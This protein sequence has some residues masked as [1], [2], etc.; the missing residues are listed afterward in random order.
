MHKNMKK[1]SKSK[2]YITTVILSLLLLWMPCVWILANGDAVKQADENPSSDAPE[3]IET[4]IDSDKKSITWYVR[5]ISGKPQSQEAYLSTD[6]I[7][8][9]ESGILGDDG[10][11]A[12][13]TLILLDNSMSIS[14]YRNSI[15][16]ILVR[17]IWNH[18]NLE[19]FAIATFDT[20]TNILVDYTDNYDELRM[21]AENITYK[22]QATYLRNVI[23]NEIIA[24]SRDKENYFSRI[25]IISDGTDDSIL[26]TTYEELT[27]LL[28][29]DATLCPI[30]TIGC[31]YKPSETGLD[32][33]FALSRLTNSPYCAMGDYEAP[34]DIADV[35]DRDGQDIR[36][37]TFSLDLE[38]LD[39]SDKVIHLLIKD[40]GGEH[41][42]SHTS[43]MQLDS[44]D[45][46]HTLI[47][48]KEKE[49]KEKAREEKAAAEKAARKEVE[50]E[51]KEAQATQAGEVRDGENEDTGA[52]E[53]N[54]AD[55]YEQ[56]NHPSTLSSY[57]M[58][59]LSQN[60]VWIMFFLLVGLAVFT[61]TA[62]VQ[63]RKNNRGFVEDTE[64]DELLAGALEQGRITKGIVLTDMNNIGVKYS[65]EIG[66]EKVVG[67][68]RSRCD[69]AFPTDRSMSARQ[70]IIRVTTDE[71]V[72]ENLDTHRGSVVDGEEITDRASLR[73]GSRIRLGNTVLR[74]T[75]E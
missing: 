40:A 37:F 4:H 13:K 36:Y 5:G 54:S 43:H 9:S 12:P 55:L 59:Y 75:Y 52:D 35:I 72:L 10:G 64:K 48:E 23:Y 1:M 56:T 58:Y 29:D 41:L 53:K 66:K 3:V 18:Q 20:K 22:D 32:K 69:I 46:L 71:A 68:L 67:R 2:I 50:K 49:E 14:P 61:T 74:V 73:N 60:V 7:A 19:Q 24:M 51:I 25:I 28:K 11:F 70:A 17:L 38:Q 26:G 21:A 33:L 16:D 62:G 30:Y 15:K 27:D 57:V 39:G 44:A 45:A 6:S 47:N 34:T 8:V 63:R 65:I 42:I 31:S